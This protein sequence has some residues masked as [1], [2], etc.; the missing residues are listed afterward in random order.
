[1]RSYRGLARSKTT[2]HRARPDL[3]GGR[4]TGP[5]GVQGNAGSIPTVPEPLHRPLR[6]GVLLDASVVPA[7]VESILRSI[8]ASENASIELVVLNGTSAS[9]PTLRDRIGIIRQAPFIAYVKLDR[10]LFGR[11]ATLDAFAPTPTDEALRGVPSLRVVPRRGRYV[12]R[13]EDSDVAVVKSYDLDVLIRFGFRVIKGAI[14]NAAKHGVWSYHHGDNRSYR[15]GP[16]LFWEMVDRAPVSGTMLQVLTE[17]LDA[18]QV[19]YRSTSRTNPIS[20]FRNRNE[21]YWKTARFVERRLADLR[22]FG[23]DSLATAAAAAAAEDHGAP[24]S[25][26]TRTPGLFRVAAF[27]ARTAATLAVSHLRHE[28][29]DGQW[30]VAWAPSTGEVP[31]IGRRPVFREVRSTPGQFLAD[32]FLAEWNGRSFMFVERCSNRRANGVIDVLEM[33]ED[34]PS[35]PVTVLERPYHLSYPAVF[36]WDGDWFMTPET[37]ANRTVELY[38]AASFPDGWEL[39]AVLL[40][41]LEAVDPTLFEHD[42]TWWLFANVAASGAS[43][44]DEL[45]LYFADSPRGPFTPHP[46]SPVVSDVRRA[47]PAGF[48]FTHDGRLYRPAQNNALRYGHSIV[49]NRVDV[50]DRERYVEVPVADILPDWLPHARCTHTLNQSTRYVVTDGQRLVRRFGHVGRPGIQRRRGRS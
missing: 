37:A 10:R 13:F 42:G 8:Q 20:L 47:R 5:N 16:A 32:P 49:L 25:R 39:D 40:H 6:V 19:I 11:A 45:H 24:S 36:Q 2:S 28:L 3:D 31:G 50:L 12:D 34:G 30:F 18:G 46:R 15:G 33:T 14:L 35:K 4:G 48:P 17:D 27:A 1:M 38:R 29:F 21:T 41:D 22:H 26:I 23:P 7:W 43:T 44:S 9:R